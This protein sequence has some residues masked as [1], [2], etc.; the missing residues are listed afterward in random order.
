MPR[1]M[2]SARARSGAKKKKKNWREWAEAPS[3]VRKTRFWAAPSSLGRAGAG[4]WQGAEIPYVTFS[5]VG[6]MKKSIF[7]PKSKVVKRC[8]IWVRGV[9]K[10][11]PAVPGND[12]WPPTKHHR[13]GKKLSNFGF[14]VVPMAGG[15]APKFGPAAYREI[16]NRHGRVL[17][18]K[19]QR[20]WAETPSDAQKTRIFA[21]PSRL[22]RAEAGFGKRAKFLMSYFQSK[23]NSGK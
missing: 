18:R 17:G 11:A 1:N 14:L 3:D 23:Q 5:N 19:N 2:K 20:E 6:K 22:R 9:E 13:L 16:Q 15:S 10:H 12:F 4:F 21:V 8:E 7:R